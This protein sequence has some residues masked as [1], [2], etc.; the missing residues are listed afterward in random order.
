MPKIVEM[1]SGRIKIEI[2]IEIWKSKYFMIILPLYKEV[3]ILI[4]NFFFIPPFNNENI[5]QLKTADK[6]ITFTN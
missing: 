6:S 2:S 4:F 3:K 5:I 1:G